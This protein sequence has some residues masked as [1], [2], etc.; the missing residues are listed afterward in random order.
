[1]AEAITIK[2][3]S[4]IEIGNTIA[5]SFK[6]IQS[7]TKS[8]VPVPVAS[9]NEVIT[10]QD[11]DIIT[12]SEKENK[13][14]IVLDLLQGIKNGIMNLVSTFT[15]SLS[16]Q[17]QEEYEKERQE[18][19]AADDPKSPVEDTSFFTK[20]FKE[21]IGNKIKSVKEG[22]SNI[23]G[24]FSKGILGKVGL[25]G[26]LLAL[27]LNIG[28]FSG[29]IAKVAEPIVKGL[30]AAFNSLKDDFGPVLM[31]V[32]KGIG[33]VFETLTNLI[34]GIFD[35]GS[36]KFTTGIKQLL[37]DLPIRLV[38]IIGDAF[39]SL[40]DAVLN[41][42]GVDSKWV[43]DIKI[44][45]RT[46]PEA[47]GKAIDNTIKFFTETIPQFF[48]DMIDQAIE[49]AKNNIAAIG[50]LFKD[51]FNFI[52]ED[53][54]NYFSGLVDKVINSIKETVQSIKD[55]ILAPI[56]AVKEKVSGFFGGVKDFFTGDDDKAKADLMNQDVKGLEAAKAK[57]KRVFEDIHEKGD[58][59]SS[60]Y[61]NSEKARMRAYNNMVIEMDPSRGPEHK[62][63][64]TMDPMLYADY[65]YRGDREGLDFAAG[66]AMSERNSMIS[67]VNEST[68]PQA[69]TP[70]ITPQDLEKGKRLREDSGEIASTRSSQNNMQINKGGT[71]NVTTANNTYTNISETTSTSDTSL[72]QYFAA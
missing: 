47:I 21:A 5:N 25:F 34:Q 65:D 46:L 9:P 41:L 45:F 2:D 28:K 14:N 8:L 1:M 17:K 56:K 72:R 30:K 44:A 29:E 40:L 19:V 50:Q 62:A 6:G 58:K 43:G 52:T 60:S 33:L 16:F 22:A 66:R 38:S 11:G 20:E 36:G 51:A 7:T 10:P 71:N 4:V 53:I 26:I 63:L 55:A 37:F 54:P 13:Q 48:N 70:T 24:F 31:N 27:A 32:I 64:N 18:R 49:N 67:A 35:P 42:F 57:Q 39:F 3:E 12:P 61:K 23:I 15:E 68:T 59:T 69:N